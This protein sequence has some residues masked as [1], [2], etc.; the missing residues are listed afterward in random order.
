M[1]ISRRHLEERLIV[2]SWEDEEFR[3]ALLQNPREVIARELSAMIGR[4]V[5]L[6]AELQIHIHEESPWSMHFILP[7]RRD[8][9]AEDDRFL[10]VGWTKLLE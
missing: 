5:E 10:V 8:E 7:Q 9:L 2:R 1:A 4:A 6:P 3:R